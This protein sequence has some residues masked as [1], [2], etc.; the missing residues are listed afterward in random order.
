MH[1]ANKTMQAI[2]AAATVARYCEDQDSCHSCPFCDPET[3]Y[4]ILR[5]NVE[6]KEWP[7]Y[8]TKIQYAME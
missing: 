5:N 4:C 7:E 1:R 6:P 8:D 2:K 3:G